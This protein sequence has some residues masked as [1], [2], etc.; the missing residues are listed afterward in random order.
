MK[1]K[2]DDL[3][4]NVQSVIEKLASVFEPGHLSTRQVQALSDAVD[5]MNSM[6]FEGTAEHPS[7][8]KVLN[9]ISKWTG[10]DWEAAFK[11]FPQLRDKINAALSSENK[12]N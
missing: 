7:T 10:D 6:L 2:A 4:Q 8:P 12:E 1:V 3:T 9:V 5:V 11:T